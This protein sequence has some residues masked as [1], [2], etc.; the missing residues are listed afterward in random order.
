MI[1]NNKLNEMFFKALSYHKNNQI[2]EAA[3]EYINIIKL[4]P[5]YFKAY[6][7]LGAINE[8][9]N[10][11]NVAK[12]LFLNAIKLNPNYIDAI[13]NLGNICNKLKDYNLAKDYFERIIKIDPRNEKAYNALGITFYNLQNFKNAKFCFQKIVDVNN[14]NYQAYYNLGK[15][16]NEEENHE[17]AIKLFNECIKIHPN[18]SNAYNNLGMAHNKLSL[19]NQ[20]KNFIEKSIEI[21]PKNFYSYNNLGIV[22]DNIYNTKKAKEN[23]N[24]A[25]NINPNFTDAWWN[26]HCCSENIDEALKVLNKL[27][28]IDKNHIKA[29]IIISALNAYNGNTNDYKELMSSEDCNHP[30][31][32][33]IDWVLSLKKLPKLFFNKWD[34]YDSVIDMTQKERPFYEY[35]VRLG[36]SFKYLIQTLKKGYGFDT[37]TGLPED[38]HSSKPKGSYSSFGIVPKIKGGEFIV[39]KFED[40]LPKF[41]EETREIASLINF[42]ADL[43]SSTICS[44]N[45]SKKII[46]NKT[47]LVFDEFLMNSNWEKDEYRAL[48]E[49]CE[50]NSYSY[51]VLAIS[52]FTKQ[53]AIRIVK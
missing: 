35:G 40:T 4:D 20:A 33:S 44:L 17:E 53:A 26:L 39:G 36:H 25:I 51:E 48:N 46:D 9:I 52:F 2:K 27:F 18:H 16:L 23:F 38:W 42:D 6:N 8:R 22:Y 21:D 47:I 28:E 31:S 7:N 19:T 41:F 3:N 50:N 13:Y 45:N 30:Y 1:E 15:I 24:K 29:K 43:Y 34:F 12:E 37:F 10:K 11:N 14:K 49:F 5:K 32:R